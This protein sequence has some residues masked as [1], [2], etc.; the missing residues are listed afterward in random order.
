MKKTF[1]LKLYWLL[2][3]RCF[4]FLLIFILGSMITNSE[5]SKISNWWSIVASIVNVC[6]LIV[7]YVI[8]TK[9]NIR[10]LDLINYT[11]GNTSKKTIVTFSIIILLFGIGGMY[12]SGFLFYGQFPYLAPMMIAPIPLSLAFINVLILPITTAFAEEGLYLG[13]GVNCIKNKYMAIFI[14][15]FFFALQHSFI[16]FLFD[17]NYILYRFF[18][19]LPLTIIICWYFYQKRN[20]LPI[21]IGHVIIDLATV[22]QILMTSAFP[23]L[24][25][26]L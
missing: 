8:A 1:N 5:L 17:F 23:E 11:K 9:K 7:L 24:Y 13:C 26:M 15:A 19:F 10:F 25:M 18:S 2:P 16:P 12:I 14:P 4:L 21:L 3:I 22:F 20:P 6:I